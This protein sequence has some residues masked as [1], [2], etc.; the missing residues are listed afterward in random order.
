VRYASPVMSK[1]E[2]VVSET[3]YCQGAQ[4]QVWRSPSPAKRERAA[5]P[6]GENRLG[7]VPLAEL[8]RSRARHGPIAAPLG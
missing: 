6:I 8:P 2:G 4:R 1:R 3:L 7:S 5:R